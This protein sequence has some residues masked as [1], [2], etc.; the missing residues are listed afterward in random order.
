MKRLLPVLCLFAMWVAPA[1]GEQFDGTWTGKTT[2]T[3]TASTYLVGPLY[4]TECNGCERVCAFDQNETINIHIKNSEVNI[5][6]VSPSYG[7]IEFQTKLDNQNAF[8]TPLTKWSS[9]G[10]YKT[11]S[12]ISG[13]IEGKV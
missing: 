1:N 9:W 3:E 12:S 8:R 10:S 2:A 13:E 6:L 5:R 7:T 11:V 4:I